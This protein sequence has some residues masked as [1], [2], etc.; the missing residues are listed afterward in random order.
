M[1]MNLNRLQLSIRCNPEFG[2]TFG[3]G[4]DN[5]IE[6][7]SN[8]TM[9]SYSNLRKAYSH[10]QYAHGTSEAQTFLAGLYKF[11]LDEIEVFQKEI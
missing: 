6:N 3:I 8:T 4:N 10:P 9:D 11:Q 7:N 1:K 2:P 5:L